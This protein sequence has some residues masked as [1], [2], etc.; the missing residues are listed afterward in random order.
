MTNTTT[1]TTGNMMTAVFSDWSDAE[2]AYK[3][4]LNRGY[5]SE[6]ISLLMSEDTRSRYAGRETEMGN[7]AAEGTGVG[8]AI[9]GTVGAIIGAIAAIGTSI[10]IPGLGLV[11]AGPIAAAL[12]GAGAGGA[13]GGLIGAL[14]GYGL[15]E[16][17]VK[18]YESSLKEGGIVLGFQPRTRAEADEVAKLW[19]SYNG[20][21]IYG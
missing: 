7:K 17:T 8:A 1:A 6:Q 19:R 18:R 15:P 2:K 13:T 12:A 9:G 20:A 14:V 16:E 11:I 3:E 10:V 4:L 5:T 21:H